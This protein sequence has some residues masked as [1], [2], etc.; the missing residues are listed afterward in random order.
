MTWEE[1]CDDPNLEDL[2]YKIEQDRFGRIVMSPRPGLPHGRYQVEI[3]HLLRTLLPDWT[4]SVE[5]GVKT[6]DGV[7]VPDVIA[8]PKDGVDRSGNKYYLPESPAICVEVLS[9]SNSPEEMDEK[10]GHYAAQGCR[11]FWTCSESGEMSFYDALTGERL[12]ASALCVGFPAR[13]VLD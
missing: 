1:I 5:T 8:F 4:V 11:E 6:P 10:R 2:P 9:E 7:K 3:A 12:A 13:I